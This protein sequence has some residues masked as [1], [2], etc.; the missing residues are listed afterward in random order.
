MTVPKEIPEKWFPVILPQQR[1]K[2]KGLDGGKSKKK[3]TGTN[4]N[5]SFANE[6]FVAS[7]T[8]YYFC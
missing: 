5:G 6:S 8:L 7:Q 3:R 4:L 1:K 2:Q